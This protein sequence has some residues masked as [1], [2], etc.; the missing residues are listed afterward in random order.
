[1]KTI[2]RIQRKMNNWFFKLVVSINTKAQLKSL[3]AKNIRKSMDLASL[4]AI[5]S[6]MTNQ[7]V[8]SGLEPEEIEV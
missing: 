3:H 7:E 4:E 6:E 1:M 5:S 8:F 2:L